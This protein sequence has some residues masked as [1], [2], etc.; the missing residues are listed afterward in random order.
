MTKEKFLIAAQIYYYRVEHSS[1]KIFDFLDLEV[2]KGIIEDI[3]Q[4]R[5]L[6]DYEFDFMV[7]ETDF[8]DSFLEDHIY[9]EGEELDDSE[10]NILS[11]EQKC[12]YYETLKKFYNEEEDL[13][14]AWAIHPVNIWY[15]AY[16]R[17]R[18]IK[19]ILD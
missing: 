10:F 16:C 8:F 19:S 3:L 11:D 7:K 6:E 12:K 15:V 1:K 9:N 13:E 4:E 18:Q 14:E 17:E 5:W 2:K